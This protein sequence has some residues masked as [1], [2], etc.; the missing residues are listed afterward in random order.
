MHNTPPNA[1]C[2]N[3][4][5]VLSKYDS[6]QIAFLLSHAHWEAMN[7][8]LLTSH[9]TYSDSKYSDHSDWLKFSG[10]GKKGFAFPCLQ[11]RGNSLKKLICLK[12]NKAVQ[13]PRHPH[14]I[15]TGNKKN[16]YNSTEHTHDDPCILLLRWKVNSKEAISTRNHVV[17]KIGGLEERIPCRR[18]SSARE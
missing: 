18:W 8:A 7:K 9:C 15:F 13:Q 10:Y 6:K 12:E 3:Q 2:R 4:L 17:L 16:C 1:K 14:K 5:K 11:F